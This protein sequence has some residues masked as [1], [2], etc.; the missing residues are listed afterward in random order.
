MI[1]MYV[2]TM[3]GTLVTAYN[4][5]ASILSNPKVSGQPINVIGA[6]GMIIVALLLFA[7]ALVIAYDAW[8]SWQK[9]RAS[10]PPLRPAPATGMD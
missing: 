3:A 7:A 6:V 10:P 9:M 2:T 8:G 5:Y 4:L 1:F